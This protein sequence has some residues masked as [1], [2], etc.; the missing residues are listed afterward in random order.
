[1]WNQKKKVNRSMRDGWGS[2]NLYGLTKTNPPL[3]PLRK[4]GNFRLMQR[5]IHCPRNFLKNQEKGDW[6][7]RVPIPFYV[8]TAVCVQVLRSRLRYWIASEMWC[9]RIFSTPSRSAIVLATLRILV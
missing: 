4:G 9:S 7:L 6:L 8:S 3:P 1:M 5:L 2:R